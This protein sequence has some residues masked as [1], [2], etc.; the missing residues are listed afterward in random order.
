MKLLIL[1][2]AEQ[3]TLRDMGVF[4][5]HPRVRIRA[6][7]IVRLSQGLTLQ[8]TATEFHVHLNSIEAWR[9]RWNRQG[10]MGLYEGHHTGAN[11]SGRLS[12]KRHC[13]H[14]RKPTAAVPIVCYGPWRK[15]KACRP[16]ARK[17]R[18][19]ICTRCSSATSATATV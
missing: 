8:Q 15:R 4:H 7:A 5:T 17:R 11:A 1:Q 6:Q 19:D 16:L 10:L 13:A 18:D 9:Q 2:Q 12:S 3:Q 14:W